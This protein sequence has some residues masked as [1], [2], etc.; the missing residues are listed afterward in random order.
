MEEM[1]EKRQK[2]SFTAWT[3]NDAFVVDIHGLCLYM[4]TWCLCDSFVTRLVSL[5]KP[6]LNQT[7]FNFILFMFLIFGEIV[8]SKNK[9]KL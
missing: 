4:T 6:S 5:P 2:N 9:I 8:V 1:I 7:I 3:K